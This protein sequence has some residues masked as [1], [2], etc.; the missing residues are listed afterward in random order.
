M[1]YDSKARH[2]FAWDGSITRNISQK[3]KFPL[4]NEEHDTPDDPGPY[5]VMGWLEGDTMVYVYDKFDTW[6][7]SL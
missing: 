2:Y 1:W 4:W 3:I 7:I 5:G 6:A